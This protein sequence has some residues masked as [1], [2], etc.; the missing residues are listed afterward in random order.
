[1]L[2]ALLALACAPVVL[3]VEDTG[4]PQP[5]DPAGGDG[6]DGGDTQPTG[7]DTGEEHVGGGDSGDPP[8][9]QLFQLD[10]LVQ[11]EIDIP[12][13]G[14]SALASAP[15]E[16]VQA[17]L[18]IDGEAFPQ[19][20]VRIKGR[21]GSYRALPAKSGLKVD[22]KEFGG[23]TKVAGQEKLN[24]NNMVQDCAKVKE[25]AAYGMHQLS[26]TPAPRVAY[27]RVHLNGEDYGVYS[28]VEALDDEFLKSRFDDPSGNLYDGD[29]FLY[30]G[31]NYYLVDFLQSTQQYFALDE[32]T[33]V[34]LADVQAVTQ[35]RLSG[36]FLNQVGA[37]VDLEQHARFWAVN[38]W[39]GQY[40]SYSYFSN[41][42]RVYFDP[43]RGGKAVFLPWDPDWAFYPDTPLHSLYGTIS[44]G[45]YSD[46]TCRGWF[47]DELAHLNEA[48]PDSALE[49]Q[50]WAAAALIRPELETD[51]K[52]EHSMA[53]VVACQGALEG[54]ID[55]RAAQLAASGI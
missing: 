52:M 15:Y 27:A 30:S 4:R 23:Q 45:C 22:L 41:N 44:Q 48:V 37:L 47:R 19:V 24:L 31:N 34:G 13:A 28:L 9:T 51:P 54:W 35:A 49:A 38:A 43:G 39:T 46:E 55:Q 29:Y 40:D 42:Y 8:Q 2:I 1:M 17:D 16:Y 7:H 12:Q 26:G 5:G 25:L 36:D 10:R 33:D 32:G 6:G 11:V 21:L 3:P 53:T 18:R 20:G 14:L 50:I